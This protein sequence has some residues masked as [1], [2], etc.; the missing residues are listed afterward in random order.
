MNVGEYIVSLSGLSGVSALDHLLAI[1]QGTGDGAPFPI[2]RRIV[3]Q[4][5]PETII[6]T[7]VRTV[8]VDRPSRFQIPAT[9]ENGGLVM[10]DGLPIT[11]EAAGVVS[12]RDA[13]IEAQAG[14]LVALRAEN[15]ALASLLMATM[16]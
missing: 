9:E 5:P 13:T 7:V 3:E 16:Q 4:S 12:A 15:E 10:V 8:Y 14:D 6:K 11:P 2:V 1:E